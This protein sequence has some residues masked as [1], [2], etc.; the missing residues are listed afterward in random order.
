LAAL[1]DY[2]ERRLPFLDA[3]AFNGVKTFTNRE[4]MLKTLY[5]TQAIK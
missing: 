3:S 5:N 4:H 1:S 2:I